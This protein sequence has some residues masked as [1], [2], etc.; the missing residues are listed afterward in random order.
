VNFQ[1]KVKKVKVG[2]LLP[3]DGEIWYDNDNMIINLTKGEKNV[4]KR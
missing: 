2:S 3:I 4:Y 1:L